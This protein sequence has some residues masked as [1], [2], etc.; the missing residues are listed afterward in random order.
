MSNINKTGYTSIF[1][2]SYTAKF[3]INDISRVH[4]FDVLWM[5]L[6]TLWVKRSANRKRYDLDDPRW[7]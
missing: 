7:L 4:L 3:F 2:R 6:L 1:K 5:S